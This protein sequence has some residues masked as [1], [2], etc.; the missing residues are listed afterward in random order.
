MPVTRHSLRT[1]RTLRVS[2][3]AL[4]LH[5][6]R[7]GLAVAGTALGVAGVLVLTAVAG[8]ARARVLDQ[9]EAL[10][11]DALIITPAPVDGRTR[12]LRGGSSAGR[13]L[14][15]GD[16]GSLATGSLAIDRAIPIVDGGRLVRNGA[17]RGGITVVGTTP[18]WQDARRFELAAGRFFT[19]AE[20]EARAR[21]A[22]L[23]MAARTRL[24]PDT[25][26]PVGRTI[27]IG[28][29]LFT[30]AGVLAAKGMSASGTATEDDRIVIPIGTA[31]R[32][33]LSVDR[34]T[35]I[36][37][38]ASSSSALSTAADEAAAILRVRH[39]LP[40]G[41]RDDF[42]IESQRALLSARLESDASFRWLLA[43]LGLVSLLVAG[44]GILSVMLLAVRERRGEIGLRRAVGARPSDVLLQF[45]A[46]ALAIAGG[47]VVVGV[48]VGAAAALV[49]S[50]A[51][52]WEARVSAGV[53]GVSIAAAILTGTCAGVLPAWRA[54]GL[55][56]VDALRSS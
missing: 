16:A 37:L 13:S 4:G 35:M 5:R 34:L 53:L 56:P 2:A 25:V 42:A 11:G 22:V 33:V 19:A 38:E 7:T 55:D 49:I 29:A 26:D 54:A 10:G 12:M 39:G 8:G 6:M 14:L 24:F 40:P 45:L 1:V 44:V 46:E 51:T 32:R 23:G 3:R 41:A 31:M 27:R 43:G 47:G 9:L 50:A 18:E 48:P 30:V 52:S 20:N 17:V 36:V 21:V 15:P 28:T